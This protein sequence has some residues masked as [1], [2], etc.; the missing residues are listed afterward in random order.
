MN[1]QF[2][3]FGYWLTPCFVSPGSASCNF[4]GFQRLPGPNIGN[5]FFSDESE[6]HFGYDRLG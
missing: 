3:S 2:G 1:W 6:P 5:D 4:G